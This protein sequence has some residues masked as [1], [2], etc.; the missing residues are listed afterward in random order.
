MAQVVLKA[1]D[2][3]PVG[4]SVSAY[5]SSRS[6]FP[7]LTGTAAQG[8]IAPAG[9]SV[10]TATVAA[11]GTLTFVNL[12]ADSQFVAY[13][14][15]GSIHTYLQFST[16]DAVA[17]TAAEVN[18]LSGASGTPNF[19]AEAVFTETTAAGVYTGSIAVPAGATIL[20]VI[21][22]GVALWAATTSAIMKVGDVAND[23]GYF[24]GID[25]KATDLLAG[26]S[27]SLESA[28]G[29]AGV[30]V[31][32]AQVSPRYAVAARTIKGTITT[33]GAA[34]ATGVTRMTVSWSLPVAVDRVTATKV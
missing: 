8:A 11:D 29:K 13:A 34:G 15:L 22:N 6:A 21:V 30:Y 26:E 16:R 1:S 9:A 2:R 17:A 27:I 5:A 3:Y 19:S 23:A 31:A 18:R 12:A 7:P 24:S 4:T 28:G 33:V 10:A 25:L 20:D 32:N 14:L